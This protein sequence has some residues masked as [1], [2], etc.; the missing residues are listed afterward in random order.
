M[1]LTYGQNQLFSKVEPTQTTGPK[2]KVTKASERKC[3]AA[4]GLEG[5]LAP[6][7]GPIGQSKESRMA[8]PRNL[9]C[10]SLQGAEIKN[11]RKEEGEA[12]FPGTHVIHVGQVTSY[13]AGSLPACFPRIR[14]GS[15]TWVRLFI[16]LT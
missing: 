11:Q 7:T 1:C 15:S 9:G 3:G 14:T 6:Q 5:W 8:A 2:W 10:A 4:R 13:P 16:T 12:G